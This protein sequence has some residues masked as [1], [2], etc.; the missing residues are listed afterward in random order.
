MVVAV[1]AGLA[2]TACSGGGA[3]G[4]SHLL[5]VIADATVRD[6][7]FQFADTMAFPYSGANT[8]DEQ[9]VVDDRAGAAS[10]TM[11]QPGLPGEES[12][13]LVKDTLY[14]R[15][16]SSEPGFSHGWCAMRGALRHS[17]GPKLDPFDALDGLRSSGRSLHRIGTENVRGVATTHYHVSGNPPLDIWVDATDRVRRLRWTHGNAHQTDTEDLYDF[18]VSASITAPASAPPCSF[19]H[20]SCTLGQSFS[21]LPSCSAS[22]ATR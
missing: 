17:G 21:Q 10:F 5:S 20:T 7:T 16:E 6:H 14:D 22:D 12:D 15:V 11:S 1:V 19:P 4:D 9:G 8:F 2:V 18:G 13:I 3:S